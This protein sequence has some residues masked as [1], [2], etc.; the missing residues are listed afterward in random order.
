MNNWREKS[1]RNGKA[2]MENKDGKTRVVKIDREGIKRGDYLQ[3]M[4]KMK[5]EFVKKHGWL[6]NESKKDIRK[7]LARRG[8]LKRYNPTIYN[9]P[10][11]MGKEDKL[12]GD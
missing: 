8:E 3:P 1:R 12:N 2:L 4:G 7:Y 5:D 10:E 6:P 9:H 11:N